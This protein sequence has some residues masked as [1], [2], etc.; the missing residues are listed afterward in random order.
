M[1]EY[2]PQLVEEH[3]IL[4]VNKFFLLVADLPKDATPAQWDSVISD[5]SQYLF[6]IVND[7]VKHPLD[8]LAGVSRSTLTAVFKSRLGAHQDLLCRF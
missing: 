3:F 4:A 1:A 5:V 6:N 8:E 7:L 2:V